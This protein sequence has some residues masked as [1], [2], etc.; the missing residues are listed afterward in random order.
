[1]KPRRVPQGLV[2]LSL[3]TPLA[4]GVFFPPPPWTKESSLADLAA[5]SANNYFFPP[6]NFF[7]PYPFF[8]PQRG[9]GWRNKRGQKRTSLED[10][11]AFS[12]RDL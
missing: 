5:R 4:S 2:A 7:L 3:S 12:W 11:H 6:S 8:S 1:M 10:E 9:G